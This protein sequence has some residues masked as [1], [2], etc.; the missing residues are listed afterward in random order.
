MERTAAI[1]TAQQW[2]KTQPVYI[3]TETTGFRN[4]DR[5]VDIAVVDFD[6]VVLF[7]TLV[8][9]CKP[10]DPE[11]AAIT[12]ITDETVKDAPNFL[13]VWA[14]LAN[15]LKDRLV[16]TYNADFDTR[17]LNQS[18]Q[19][20]GVLDDWLVWQRDHIQFECAMLL[21]ADYYGDYNDYRHSNRWQK[22]SVAAQQCGIA[23]PADLHRARADAELARRVVLHMAKAEEK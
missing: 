12:G 9:P 2:I 6:G 16:I 15:V 1:L 7:E 11:A 8:N 3:D 4:D 14:R 20:A 13:Q 18:A 19:A 22:L 5:V 10:I 23:V 21:Y 17:L